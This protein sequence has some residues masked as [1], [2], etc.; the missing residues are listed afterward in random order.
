MKI[1]K[2][3]AVWNIFSDIVINISQLIDSSRDIGLLSGMDLCISIYNANNIEYYYWAQNNR[4][5]D[6]YQRKLR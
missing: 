3:L 2:H 5:S 6:S 4:L 1:L